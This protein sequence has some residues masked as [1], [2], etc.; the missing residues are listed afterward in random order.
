MQGDGLG[1]GEE[2][3]PFPELQYDLLF[4]LRRRG[5]E[6]APLSRRKL[7]LTFCSS[8]VVLASFSSRVN[9]FTCS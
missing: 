7:R 9:N 1:Y 6:E 4:A 2:E 5:G 3:A 8:A